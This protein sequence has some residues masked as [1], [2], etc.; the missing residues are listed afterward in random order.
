MNYINN[1]E[2]LSEIVIFKSTCEYNEKGKYIKGSGT[3]SNELGE[4]VLLMCKNLAKKSSFSKY[5]WKED[6]ISNSIIIIFLYLHNFDPEKYKNAF[7]Y[8]TTVIT[9]SFWQYIKK[10]NKHGDIKKRLYTCQSKSNYYDD[11]YF[12]TPISIDYTKFIKE[13]SSASIRY[14]NK[15]EKIDE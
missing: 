12:F 13:E 14:L 1:K 15:G 10:Q 11:N 3:I 4:M 7:A 6:M 9:R 8:I 5:S 2:L